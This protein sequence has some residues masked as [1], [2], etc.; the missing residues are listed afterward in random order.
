VLQVELVLPFHHFQVL[1][2]RDLDDGG[3]HGDAVL[4]ALAGAD[5]DLVPGEVHVFDPKAGALQ[6]PQP[7]P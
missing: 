3:Q 6:Q 2:E 1:G 4:V 7:M 5:R